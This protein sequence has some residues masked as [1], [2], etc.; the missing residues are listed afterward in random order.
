EKR[1]DVHLGAFHLYLKTISLSQKRSQTIWTDCE[2]G[3]RVATVVR[4][5]P[6]GHRTSVGAPLLSGGSD[7]IPEKAIAWNACSVCC[8]D[9]GWQDL[10][11]AAGDR[12]PWLAQRDDHDRREATPAAAP[13]VRRRDRGER[14]KFEAL[15]AASHRTAEGC[16]Q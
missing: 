9:G 12:H 1:F 2:F 7:E 10:P 11:C 8:H 6:S 15:V 5:R 16:A 4:M 14:K 3:M 13:E